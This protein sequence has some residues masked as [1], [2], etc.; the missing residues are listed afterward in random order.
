MGNAQ[1]PSK[2]PP[3]PRNMTPSPHSTAP[4]KLHPK[5]HIENPGSVEELHM[6]FKGMYPLILE[7]IRL[8]VL[9]G[10]SNHLSVNH[11]LLIGTTSPR[12]NY[13]FGSTF[14]A[15]NRLEHGDFNPLFLDADIDPHGNITTNVHVQPWNNLQFKIN[16][17]FQEFK[18]DICQTSVEYKADRYTASLLLVDLD[19]FNFTGI[20]ISQCLYALN[21]KTSVGVEVTHH[22]CLSLPYGH[23][24][25][26]DFFG[27]YKYNDATT[28]ST[29]FNYLELQCYFHFKA[30][31]QHQFGLD[32]GGSLYHQEFNATFAYQAK[33]P[34]SDI[35]IKSSID[36]KWNVKTSLEKSLHPLTFAFNIMFFPAQRQ[37]MMG[38]GLTIC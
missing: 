15:C 33:I 12:L 30:S 18:T 7:G 20:Y 36:R 28:I 35:V 29:K 6:E 34:T 5:N 4:Q 19:L 38:A 10:L 1:A 11:S 24:T 23:L 21:N 17:W 8:N 2:L 31:E 26:F 3:M 27:R 32:L 25:L 13:K 9:T 16:A 14:V 37:L 22:R